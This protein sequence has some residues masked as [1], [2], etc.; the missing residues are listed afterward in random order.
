MSG[1]AKILILLAALLLT[2]LEFNIITCCGHFCGLLK[3]GQERSQMANAGCLGPPDV[4][5][6]APAKI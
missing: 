2:F 1:K 5:V 4:V 3:S 6:T